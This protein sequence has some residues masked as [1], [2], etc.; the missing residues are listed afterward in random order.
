MRD[1][2]NQLGKT[3]RAVVVNIALNLG[4]PALLKFVKLR[5]N[6]SDN[7]HRVINNL[8]NFIQTHK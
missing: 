3:R 2:H 5:G 8:F 1:S 7:D 6:H 4:K